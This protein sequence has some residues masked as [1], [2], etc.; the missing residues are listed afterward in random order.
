MSDTNW[1]KR[2]VDLRE[3][4][5]VRPSMILG[6][7]DMAHLTLGIHRPLRLMYDKPTFENPE[8][9]LLRV[10]PSQ[11]HC[12]CE[13][14]PLSSQIEH[15]ID[16]G[17]WDVLLQAFRQIHRELHRGP[18]TWALPFCEPTFHFDQAAYIVTFAER[19]A[20]AIRTSAGLWCQSY[21]RGWPTTPP[22]LV[23][24]AGSR[25][26]LMVVAA[27]SPDWF[28]GLPFTRQA[29][30]KAI[31][32]YAQPYVRLE[33]HPEDDLVPEC[34]RDPHCILHAENIEHWL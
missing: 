15:L 16:W 20:V 31:P 21:E 34:P 8:S 1:S 23:Q 26:G 11:V 3:Y 13:S 29:V 9:A 22:F 4:V 33:W 12:M 25:V 24:D 27:L 14:G 6:A 2:L 19:G 10:S 5:K 7:L 32:D 17:E 18:G 30:E 28:P